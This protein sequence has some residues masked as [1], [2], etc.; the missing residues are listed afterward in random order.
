MELKL[1]FSTGSYLD[2]LQIKGEITEL[3]T[4]EPAENYVVALYEAYDTLDPFNSPPIYLT[5]SNASGLY[6]LD[7]LKSGIYLIYA[8]S[9][10]NKNLKLDSR[11]EMHGFYPV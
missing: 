3:L 4:H 9:D 6:Q 1:A 7:N 8:I 11:S 2:S 5:R 10:N